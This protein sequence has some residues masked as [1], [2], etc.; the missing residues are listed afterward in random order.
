MSSSYCWGRKFINISIRGEINQSYWLI[1]RMMPTI[2]LILHQSWKWNS[3]ETC[4]IIPW[5][6]CQHFGFFTSVFFL[7][8]DLESPFSGTLGRL[9]SEVV[10]NTSA[11]WDVLTVGGLTTPSAMDPC[12]FPVS[13]LTISVPLLSGPLWLPISVQ[14]NDEHCVSVI[15]IEQHHQLPIVYVWK[16]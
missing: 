4:S 7:V 6:N 8:L 2:T 11:L 10:T 9:L 13:V 16:R 1:P 5:A 3:E 15:Q 12:Q 14:A